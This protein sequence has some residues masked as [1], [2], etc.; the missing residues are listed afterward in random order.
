MVR[1]SALYQLTSLYSTRCNIDASST[2]EELL[3]NSVPGAGDQL[4]Q[5]A[6]ALTA[7]TRPRPALRWLRGNGGGA[8]L[9]GLAAGHDPVT[10]DLLDQLPPSRSLHFL[11]DRLVATGSCPNAPSTSTASRPG[12]TI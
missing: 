7:S 10:H 5:P 2:L 8:I 4:R 6:E 12:S 1:I 3:G 9:A 11:R